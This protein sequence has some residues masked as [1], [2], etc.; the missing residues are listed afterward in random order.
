MTLLSERADRALYHGKKSAYAERAASA[1]QARSPRSQ[2]IRKQRW[3]P[4]ALL[5]QTVAA[6]LLLVA[7]PFSAWAGPD[8]CVVVGDVVTCTGD[9]SQGIASGT[10]FTTPPAA[11]LSV[12]SLSGEITP[13]F[14]GSGISFINS[15]AS[16]VTV[17]VGTSGAQNNPVIKTQGDEGHPAPGINASSSGSPASYNW[18][19][20]LGVYVP[21]GPAGGGGA[22]SVENYGTISTTGDNS[23][24]M[25]AR[26]HHR[27]LQPRLYFLSL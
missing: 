1:R 4:C 16:P 21:S 11:T 26:D 22:V 18:N 20:A 5:A 9:Q 10:D 27:H 23:H 3:A 12:N 17:T 19:S 14:G 24:G 2:A 6:C 13:T 25:V 15:T 7:S 8:G